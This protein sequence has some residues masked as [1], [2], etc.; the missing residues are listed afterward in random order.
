MRRMADGRQH[1]G[2]THV[3]AAEHADFAVG[4]GKGSRPLDG[5]VT[6]VNLVFER[7]PL[8]FGGV[9]TAHILNDDDEAAQGA[10]TAEVGGI[11]FVVG[12]AGEEDG[13]GSGGGWLIDVRM[14]GDAIAGLHGDVALNSNVGAW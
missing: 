9:A 5:V 4:M 8:A 11:V 6:V 7:I 3:G 2:G 10:T 14:E 1:L 12:G 13:I